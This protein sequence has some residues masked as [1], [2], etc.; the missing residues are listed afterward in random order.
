M[1]SNSNI[2]YQKLDEFIKKYY[3]N[4]LIQG[5]LIG[6]AGL[7]AFIL[8]AAII[9]YFGHFGT[10]I[11]A[12]MFF[13]FLVFSIFILIVFIVIPLLKRL[14]LTKTITYKDASKMVGLHFPEISDR[15]LNTIQLQEQSNTQDNELLIASINQ[16]IETLS[17]FKFSTAINLKSSAKKYGRYTLLP[18]SMILL[19]LIF[20]S[21]ILTKPANRILSYNQQ[22]VKEAPFEF[23]LKSSSL[24]VVR[25]SDFNIEL[26]L[27]G[28]EIPSNIFVEI[29]GNRIK[30]ENK[31]KNTFTHL[32][33]N[34]SNDHKIKF[35]DGEY[36]S[37]TYLIKVLPNPTLSGFKV[38]L[39]YP[40]YIKKA[41]EVLNNIGDFTV[42]EGTKAEWIFNTSDADE[43]L[44]S[45]YGKNSSIKPQDGDFV[46]QADLRKSTNYFLQL[47]NKF[48]SRKDTVKYFIQTVADRYPGIVAEQTPDSLNQNRFYFYGKVDDDY[49]I[50]KLQFVYKSLSGNGILKSLPVNIGKSTDEIFYYM[51]DLKSL[52]ISD[53]E[54][55]EYYFEV[56]DNDAVNGRKSS[57]SQVFRSVSPS[58]NELR[59]ESESSS[60]SLKNKLSETMKEIQNLQKKSKDLSKEL[61]ESNE[62]DWMKEQKL[63]EFLEE[64][65]KLEEKLEELKKDNLNNNEKQKQL[66]PLEQEI[67]DK[68]KELEK[69]FNEVMS[70]EMKDLLKKLEEMLKQQNKDAI[71][72]QLEKMNQSNEEMK[73]QLDR[74]LEQYKQLEVEKRINQEVNDLK[75]LAEEQKELAKKTAE[76]ALPKEELIK[77][78]Q[79]INKKFDELQKEID[80]TLE[81][82]KELETPLNLEDLQKEKEAIQENL[83][84]SEQNLDNKQNKKANEKQKKAA[85]DMEAMADK[86][87]KSL[88][89]AQEE[90]EEEDY[91]ALRQILENLIELSVQQE[92]LMTAMKDLRSYS[93]KYVELSA[94]Q[95][96]LK[97]NA[98][99]VEDSLLAL[100]KRQIQIK[101]FVN[102]E[103]GNINFNM[104][105]AIES[106]SKI[107]ISGGLTRQQY[108][109]TG[110]NN[111]AV[112]L[113]ESL[114]NMQE[115]MKE[116]KNKSNAQCK[117]PGKAQSKPGQSGKPKMSGMKQMQDDINKQMQEMKDG[118]KQGK[119][120]GAEQYAKLAAKQEALR[121]EVERL[122]KMLKEEGK[123]GALGDLEKTKQ[124]MEQVEKDLVNKQIT[125]ET[126]RRVQ[127][128]E[129]RMLEHEKAE[130]E[131]KT[132][133]QREAEQAK[134]IEREMPAA[135]KAYLE[136]KAREMELLR[137][138][139]NELSP[140]YK[141][142]VRSYFQ[143]VGSI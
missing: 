97:D 30:M 14:K 110:L 122:Q 140:Y 3:L 75:K 20:Q 19:I 135:M 100:S 76:K 61:M 27:K 121:R 80:K 113:S 48:F 107:Y 17:P 117:N 77:Q 54:E 28:K 12:F 141:D 10:A 44:F 134:E 62:M 138:V 26:L 125:P 101:S 81:K 42:P 59:A 115:S 5:L 82:N 7:L 24:N 111:L 37:V 128:I 4:R 73:K 105:E 96:K 72:E 104:D 133:N 124:L 120:P 40:S 67:L 31:G 114:K 21:S 41:D 66:D 92:N 34:L 65:K 94:Q 51:I 6:G 36:E 38:K 74:A 118:K 129:T 132:D 56:W 137:S 2:L 15:L 83:E 45:I 95:R 49:G 143:K 139:P 47:K 84:Q 123:P 46:L 130:N 131:Q 58:Q 142:R 43:M 53:G 119:N 109:M 116:K 88:D 85:E 55:F 60:T 8:L 1:Q 91:Y 9:E 18:L 112:M 13:S 64:Q 39:H 23:I 79:E 89:K 126:L 16:R 50:S 108:V 127:E 71:Q 103:I 33:L 87:E 99:M 52:S 32:L 106:F 57:K 11:R 136:K 25:N 68:Q 35:T 69:L 78:Q 90:Q 98:K 102:K 86:M 22:F 93:P 63:K 29:D 70:P